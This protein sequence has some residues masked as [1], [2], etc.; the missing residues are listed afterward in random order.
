MTHIG[1]RGA[2]KNIGKYLRLG[3]MISSP[4]RSKSTGGSMSFSHT[5]NRKNAPRLAGM[6]LATSASVHAWGETTALG[7]TDTG[8]LYP[9]P[10]L[11]AG[12]RRI[13]LAG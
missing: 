12:E 3:L 6:P 5:G 7:N 13:S 4:A 8:L 2:Q 11:R 1:S 9:I 10:S